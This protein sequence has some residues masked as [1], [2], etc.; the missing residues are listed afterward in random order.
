MNVK[1]DANAFGSLRDSP[2]RSAIRSGAAI[3]VQEIHSG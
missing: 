3:S 1:T 2:W